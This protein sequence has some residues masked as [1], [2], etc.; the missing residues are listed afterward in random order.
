MQNPPPYIKFVFTVRE[1]SECDGDQGMP[2]VIWKLDE[3]VRERLAHLSKL[4]N[5]EKV[6]VVTGEFPL[7]A[8]AALNEPLESASISIAPGNDPTVEIEMEKYVK[9]A[10]PVPIESEETLFL[11]NLYVSMGP[12][13]YMKKPVAVKNVGCEPDIILFDEDEL[14]DGDLTE[15]VAQALELFGSIESKEAIDRFIKAT[16]VKDVFLAQ[17]APVVK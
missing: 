2:F 9:N 5:T 7:Y 4:A 13:T 10:W 1:R 8:D 6:T 12:P 17:K 15:A 11:S 14:A 16:G 3:S